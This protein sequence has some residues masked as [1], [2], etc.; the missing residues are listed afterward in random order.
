[1]SDE[2]LN[3]FKKQ[4]NENLNITKHHI[5]NSGSMTAASI[6]DI[7]Q[8]SYILN[9]KLKK[10]T[11]TSKD[12]TYDLY[13][14][15]KDEYN[16]LIK[17]TPEQIN[18]DS[19]I[20]KDTNTKI[21]TIG[22]GPVGLCLSKLIHYKKILSV[23]N[24]IPL[25][26]YYN[27]LIRGAKPE[28]KTDYTSYCIDKR[29]FHERN[30]IL[31]LTD[32]GFDAITTLIAY[33]MISLAMTNDKNSHFHILDKIKSYLEE[34]KL[35]LS[36]EFDDVLKENPSD[37]ASVKAA[38][39]AL[40]AFDRADTET[41]DMTSFKILTLHIL[42]DLQENKKLCIINGPSISSTGICY[43]L[44]P[45]N[46]D[47]NFMKDIEL[48]KYIIDH[49]GPNFGKL[50]GKI[51]NPSRTPVYIGIS[52]SSL[53]QIIDSISVPGKKYITITP[54]GEIDTPELVVKPIKNDIYIMPKYKSSIGSVVSYGSDKIN[55]DQ[56]YKLQ[57]IKLLIGCDGTNS[58]IRKTYFSNE[59]KTKYEGYNACGGGIIFN[60]S[61]DTEHEQRRLLARNEKKVENNGGVPIQIPVPTSLPGDLATNL[62]ID[63]IK[64][65]LKIKDFPSPE[66][67]V[68]IFKYKTWERHPFTNPIT[69]TQDSKSVN[70]NQV[71]TDEHNEVFN[72]FCQRH[73][74]LPGQHKFRLFNTPGILY[75]G[76]TFNETECDL[77]KQLRGLVPNTRN[78]TLSKIINARDN[79][80]LLSQHADVNID[81]RAKSLENAVNLDKIYNYIKQWAIM[82]MPIVYYI[83]N[84]PMLLEKYGKFI[85]I[86]VLDE[87]TPHENETV[88]KRKI[89]NSNPNVLLVGDSRYSVHFFSGSG[90]N[91]GL[92]NANLIVNNNDLFND[93]F[94]DNSDNTTYINDTIKQNV[95]PD[96]QLINLRVGYDYSKK[97]KLLF[98]TN[99]TN[100]HKIRNMDQYENV[101]LE[102][103]PI[104]RA[105]GT[106]K[107]TTQLK[108]NPNILTHLNKV[109]DIR[110]RQDP[111]DSDNI[112]LFKDAR[113]DN[114]IFNYSKTLSNKIGS[115]LNL[116]SRFIIFR[117]NTVK[118]EPTYQKYYEKSSLTLK[119]YIYIQI[120]K[121]SN[122]YIYEDGNPDTIKYI[123]DLYIYNNTPAINRNYLYPNPCWIYI[124]GSG[125][126]AF[127]RQY[128]NKE[129]ALS[130]RSFLGLVQARAHAANAESDAAAAEAA[131]KEAH[132]LS[133]AVA[134]REAAAVAAR[135]AVE[136]RQAEVVAATAKNNAPKHSA[137]QMKKA[138]DTLDQSVRD[139]WEKAATQTSNH[140]DPKYINISSFIF[141]KSITLHGSGRNMPHMIAD[142]MIDNFLQ[143]TIPKDIYN[144][145]HQSITQPNDVLYI[146]KYGI[147][148][149]LQPT[150]AN[151]HMMQRQIDTIVT[152]IVLD[153]KSDV[154]ELIALIIFYYYF[155]QDNLYIINKIRKLVSAMELIRN[156]LN[157]P[158]RHIITNLNIILDIILHT[159][160][161]TSIDGFEINVDD[162]NQLKIIKDTINHIFNIPHLLN[163]RL[164]HTVRLD[165]RT[166]A[167]SNESTNES[168]INLDRSDLHSTNLQKVPKYYLFLFYINYVVRN[169]N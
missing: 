38:S 3:L 13:L 114:D 78:I 125:Y 136:Q 50:V 74:C 59:Y 11:S 126:T 87:I 133:E 19:Y 144:V 103:L 22:R 17:I 134:V 112:Q 41:K 153:I 146:S 33:Y 143:E 58:L 132:R 168:W 130:R 28:L 67:R 65:L 150:F 121:I 122:I 145:I 48:Y 52:I 116:P 40:D 24:T 115:V 113:T 10:M 72:I 46:T 12:K 100:T 45:L 64:K 147:I 92:N 26:E 161:D 47:D 107:P 98:E 91:V 142:N 53:Q 148:E 9:T 79:E 8:E 108:G 32:N 99:D 70:T 160:I 81:Q 85:S 138:W 110:G 35:K 6:Q 119:I 104:M 37:E 165:L 166:I 117:Y 80:T 96:T 27:K 156:P 23:D 106:W 162:T 42:T 57:N 62:N 75:L 97:K 88:F 2:L 82:Q 30:Q 124:H 43:T 127:V 76:L 34:T 14:M 60:Y 39:D 1:M 157:V 141:N 55:P 68:D 5:I 120:I 84:N 159:S 73:N 149:N 109:M 128:I 155:G 105:D 18:F 86:F 111:T 139:E 54:V 51:K 164:Y 69:I 29:Q 20:N 49:I 131:A 7:L 169:F 31:V 94:N 137:E 56:S 77:F 95:D 25:I 151:Y 66:N 135:E 36:S 158:N 15:P 167:F 16:H 129:Q 71:S 63:V 89:A 61:Y 101:L 93:L 4:F 123:I 152:P 90:V 154:F 140:W 21:V 83:I 118:T 44:K 102:D 163:P